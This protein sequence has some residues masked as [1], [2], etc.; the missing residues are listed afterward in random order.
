MGGK[1]TFAALVTNSSYAEKAV[2]WAGK[3]PVAL[4]MTREIDLV[5]V[6]ADKCSYKQGIEG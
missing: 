3:H 2:Y 6:S 1:Q 5:S 4:K